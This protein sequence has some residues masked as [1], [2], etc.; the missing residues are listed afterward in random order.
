MIRI[1]F[2][3]GLLFGIFGVYITQFISQYREAYHLWI[4]RIVYDVTDNGGD[5]G[6]TDSKCDKKLCSKIESYSREL[7]TLSDTLL[8]LFLCIC[9]TYVILFV[10]SYPYI[11]PIIFPI[12]NALFNHSPLTVESFKNSI[13][14][15][16]EINEID[17]FNWSLQVS[18]II[19]ATLMLFYGLPRLLKVSNIDIFH[20]KRTSSIDE[21]LFNVWY[22]LKCFE[23]K[24][25][26]YQRNLK[27][28][29]LYITLGRKYINNEKIE[30]EDIE[31]PS[32][33]K[34]I[35]ILLSLR[36]KS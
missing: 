18:S 22:K 17:S 20:F 19:I 9:V 35:I 12:Y 16:C 30:G 14:H 1:L 28:D 23:L 32:N 29:Q 33:L 24:K 21:K 5:P 36:G 31:I 10:V 2:F 27:P 7:C 15:F 3:F 34:E 13:S 4:Q 25:E 26:K 8:L 6:C 11:R